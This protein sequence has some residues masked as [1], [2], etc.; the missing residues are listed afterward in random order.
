MLLLLGRDCETG[1][2]DYAEVDVSRGCRAVHLLLLDIVATSKWV[3]YGG[4]GVRSGGLDATTLT[5]PDALRTLLIG[6][7]RPSGEESTSNPTLDPRM[8]DAIAETPN[9]SSDVTHAPTPQY[10]AFDGLRRSTLTLP[11]PSDFT[12]AFAGSMAKEGILEV[13]PR[14]PSGRYKNAA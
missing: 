10:A 1:E 9:S 3:D 14:Q 11:R 12:S 4:V 6:A 2:F 13:T 5:S 7:C 8:D